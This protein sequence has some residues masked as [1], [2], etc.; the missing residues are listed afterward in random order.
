MLIR[1]DH[2]AN[3]IKIQRHLGIHE[4]TLADPKSVEAL[5]KAPTG[6]AG[7]IGLTNVQILADYAIQGL[8]N[9]IVGGNEIDTHYI[10]ANSERDFTIDVLGDFRQAQAGDLSPDGQGK[11][12]TTRG[13]EVG[14]VFMLG[15]KYSQKMNATYLDTHGKSQHAVMGCYGIGV[16]RT[17]AAA[18]EQNHDDR[19]IVWPIPIAP[20]HVHLLP[21]SASEAVLTVTNTLYTE[22][23]TRPCR[24]IT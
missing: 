17:V 16:G 15:T 19:G 5:T 8:S 6:F 2:Q 12:E 11:L 3:E 7:P 10:N 23:Q 4:L 13:I 21:I 14:H 1:G 24:G 9:F 18:I 22:L 20:F